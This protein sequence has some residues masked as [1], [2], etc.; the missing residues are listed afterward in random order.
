MRALF[1]SLELH[2]VLYRPAWQGSLILHE[3]LSR[4]TLNLVF[5]AGAIR[6]HRKHREGHGQRAERHREAHLPA[7]PLPVL[8]VR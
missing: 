2:T 5:D 3:A 1:L 4:H 7:V 6:R 8:Q